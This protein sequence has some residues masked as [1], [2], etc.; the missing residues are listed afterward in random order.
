MRY[1]PGLNQR[2][3]LQ[4]RMREAFS[5]ARRL[6][7]EATYASSSG[8][9]KL[10]Q[11]EPPRGS[12]AVVDLGFGISD[13]LAVEELKDAG[14]DVWGIADGAVSASAL[15][16]KLYLAERAGELRRSGALRTSQDRGHRV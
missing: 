15:H 3:A 12:R 4:N 10:L 9:S 6:H 14:I 7:L 2:V 8:T 16:P 5:G 1:E 13:P 11:L